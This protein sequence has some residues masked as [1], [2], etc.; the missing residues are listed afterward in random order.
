MWV[1]MMTAAKIDQG[2]TGCRSACTTRRRRPRTSASRPPRG[3]VASAR[4]IGAPATISGA[5]TNTI[6]RCWTMWTE[7]W[8]SAAASTPGSTDTTSTAMPEPSRTRR[9]GRIRVRLLDQPVGAALGPGLA[10][11]PGDAEREDRGADQD[12][13]EPEVEPDD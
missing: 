10:D 12:E 11:E 7:S 3:S 13:V 8:R 1:P 6:S 4:R 2:T 5:A 9:L